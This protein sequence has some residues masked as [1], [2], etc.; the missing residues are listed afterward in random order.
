MSGWMVGWMVEKR[1]GT[2]RA[3]QGGVVFMDVWVGWSMNGWVDWMDRGKKTDGWMDEWLGWRMNGM[4]LSTKV[5]P[6]VDR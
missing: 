1:E 3:M 5:R 2:E 4:L 6:I